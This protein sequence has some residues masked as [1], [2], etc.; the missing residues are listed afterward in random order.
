M[1]SVKQLLLS[2]KNKSNRSMETNI[3]LKNS[4]KLTLFY[5]QILYE[6]LSMN[7]LQNTKNICSVLPHLKLEISSLSFKES[8]LIQFIISLKIRS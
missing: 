6:K 4:V 5:Y 8:D 3:I 2:M 7:R 1:N